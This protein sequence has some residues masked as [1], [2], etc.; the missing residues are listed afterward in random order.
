MA[1][2]VVQ[3]FGASVTDFN[4]KVDDWN[5][6]I[7]HANDD[8]KADEIYNRLLPAYQ[9]A[10]S[11]LS[12]A[13]RGSKRS[14]AN[15]DS[16]TNII[17]L[18]KA[19]A[20]PP[21]AKAML[22]GVGLNDTDLPEMPPD[23]VIAL[24]SSRWSEGD[25]DPEVADMWDSIR[26]EE[27]KHILDQIAENLAKKY[28][29]DEPPN[30]LFEPLQHDAD[31]TLLGDYR[32]SDNRLRLN[33]RLLDEPDALIDTVAHEMRHAGQHQWADD[34]D[35]GFWGFL[36]WVD[37]SWDESKHPP[38]ITKEDAEEFGNN[39]DDYTSP[40]DDFD[41]YR[42]QPVESDA[43]EAGGDYLDDMTPEKLE[44]IRRQAS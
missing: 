16:D 13:A 40:E 14:L 41:D 9:R 2:G 28:G 31:G 24:E 27:R 39:F 23:S 11:A 33:Q 7:R 30:V 42:N 5:R 3:A 6:Q 15:W 34:A 43:R 10:A 38:D 21:S 22:P 32:D 19:G 18:W 17:E 4:A 35:P 12:E 8:D 29:V 44:R 26:D 1:G 25:L 36:P 37:D 20:L